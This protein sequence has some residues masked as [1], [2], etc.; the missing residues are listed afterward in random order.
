MS[1]QGSQGASFTLHRGRQSLCPIAA[2]GKMDSAAL[3]AA[4][5]AAPT[6]HQCL[7]LAASVL[8]APGLRGIWNLPAQKVIVTGMAGQFHI[9][10]HLCLRPPGRLRDGLE[11]LTL[12]PWCPVGV[13]GGVQPP[14]LSAPL[15]VE[16]GLSGLRPVPFSTQ[17]PVAFTSAP[18]ATH[19]VSR[20]PKPL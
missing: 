2:P 8:I 7:A 19:M 20:S 6:P 18:G 10:V 17:G 3:G 4:P 1:F 11:R 12:L 14:L 9:R 5:E 13:S 16:V 15:H